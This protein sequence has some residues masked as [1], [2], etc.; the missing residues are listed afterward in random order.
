MDL[1]TRIHAEIRDRVAELRPV[2][3]E[4]QRLAEALKALDGL[5]ASRTTSAAPTG[6]RRRAGGRRRARKT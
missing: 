3:D 5:S 6:R 2:Y 1:L 4:H